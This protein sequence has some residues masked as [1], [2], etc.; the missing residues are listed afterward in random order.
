MGAKLEVSKRIVLQGTITLGEVSIV[1]VSATIEDG[2]AATTY[3]NP[4]DVEA[5]EKNK[6]E[7]RKMVA[8]FDKQKYSEEDKRQVEK[9]SVETK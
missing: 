3:I 9:A 6:Q 5:Y 1:E 4:Y 8:E 7:M 2:Q